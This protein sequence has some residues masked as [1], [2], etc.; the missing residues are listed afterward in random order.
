MFRQAAAGA[1]MQV[2]ARSY[3]SLAAID[4]AGAADYYAKAVAAQEKLTGPDHPRV[5]ILLNRLAT[6]V[7]AKQGPR[8][9]EVLLRRALAIQRKT[10]G[11]SPDTATTLITLGSLLQNLGRP[12]EAER[13]ER[14]AVGI[15][16]QKRPQSVQLATAYTNLADLLS[17]RKD[18]TPSAALLRHA[19]AIDEAIYGTDD[20][21]VALD[22]SNLGE[23][24]KGHGQDAAART[25]FA[26]ALAIYEK[27]LGS[28]S[29]EARGVRQSLRTLH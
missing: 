1:D 16:E 27:R 4:P 19:I 24:L 22:L 12:E 9:A 5:A 3:A 10:L 26:R 2:A 21:E 14:D 6:A 11:A 29:P 20:P 8:E 13:L 25:A 28:E 17:A 23:L 7:E 18:F 15:L